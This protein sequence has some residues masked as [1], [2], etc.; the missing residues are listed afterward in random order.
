MINSGDSET[1]P[2]G[3]SQ[4]ETEGF[5]PSETFNVIFT[6]HITRVK[7]THPHPTK[8]QQHAQHI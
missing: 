2:A 3:L 5:Y 6:H 7:H 1:V 4:G 8:I